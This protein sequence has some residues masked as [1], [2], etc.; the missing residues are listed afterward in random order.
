MGTPVLEALEVLLEDE[1][2]D[3]AEVGG[4]FGGGKGGIALSRDEE[5]IRR[6]KLLLC[7]KECGFIKASG[8]VTVVVEGVGAVAGGSEEECCCLTRIGVA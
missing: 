3:E 8:G 4:F 6:A 2:F 7:S 5:V 1:G